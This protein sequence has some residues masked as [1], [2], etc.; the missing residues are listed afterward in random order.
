MTEAKASSNT[1]SLVRSRQA[2]SRLCRWVKQV[3]L[4]HATV[5]GVEAALI[6]TH[7]FSW[8]GAAGCGEVG[9]NDNKVTGM[10]RTFC[11]ICALL[12]RAQGTAHLHRLVIS[13]TWLVQHSLFPLMLT[14]IFDHLVDRENHP[15]RVFVVFCFFVV[16]G[17]FLGGRGPFLAP[18]E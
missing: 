8:K 9:D 7:G 10:V 3:V 17:V 18:P 15:R 6:T 12:G 4:R 1:V 2:F 14:P 16:L 13:V 11:R 5:V